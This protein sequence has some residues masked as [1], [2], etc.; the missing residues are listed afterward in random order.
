M[1]VLQDILGWAGDRDLWQQDALRRLILQAKLST[2]DLEELTR[3]CL[4]E[5]A[6]IDEDHRAPKAQPLEQKHLPQTHATSERVQLVGI[7]DVKNVNILAPEQKMGFELDGLT[8]VF[9]YNGSGKSGYARILR[10][11]CHAR[12]RSDQI[13]PD[14]FAQGQPPTPSATIDFREGDTDTTLQWEQGSPV[15]SMLQQVSFFDT[16]CATVHVNEANE[17]A[18]TPFGLDVMPKL[19]KVCHHI[20]GKIQ[21]MITEQENAKPTFLTVPQAAEGTDVRSAIDRI[22]KDS[23]IEQFQ[24]LANLTQEDIGR[25]KELQEMLATDPVLRTKE[26]RNTIQRLGLLRSK[27]L[28]VSTA[29]SDNAVS[30]L[31]ELYEYAKTKREAAQFVANDAFGEQP[32]AGVGEKIWQE[33]WKAARAYSTVHAYPEDPF[34]HTEND[35]RCVLCHQP[36]SDEARTRL[37]KFENFMQA[38]TQK[39]ADDAQIALD[40][41]LRELEAVP[42]GR[43]AIHEH[44]PDIP[45]GQENLTTALRRF[46]GMAWKRRCKIQL[47]RDAPTW[48]SP[49][50]LPT[51]PLEALDT[52]I[53]QLK[54]RA[55]EVDKSADRDERSKLVQERKNLEARQWLAKVLGDINPEISRKRTLASLEDAR[56]STTT[57]GITRQ[58]TTLTRTYVTDV[59]CE[60]MTEEI[61]VLGAGH[62]RVGLEPRGGQQGTQLYQ[63][64]LDGVAEGLR[65]RDV[66]SE[67]EFRCIALAGFLA[68][69]ST[70][71]S[72]SALVFDDPVS[73]L[74]HLWRRR[75]AQRLVKEAADRQVV[76]FTHEIGFLTDLTEFCAK[77]DIRQQCCYLQR[78]SYH[79]GVCLD[80]L[81]WPAM[82]LNDRIRCL[83]SW[84]QKAHDLDGDAYEREA[85]RLYGLLRECWERAVEEVLLNGVITRFER[86]V[87]TMRLRDVADINEEDITAVDE[88]MAKCSRFLTGHDEP[89]AVMDPVPNSDELQTDISALGEWAKTIR[90]RRN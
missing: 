36:L 71:Q 14:A 9:G 81:P 73:S 66:L 6:I 50:Q 62:L 46:H 63:L 33:L 24:E 89:S 31:K 64:A 3:I 37:N 84:L 70:E 79:A 47:C 76:V 90:R 77:Q 61:N 48:E 56:R 41:A 22:N 42:V 82:K 28:A 72:G 53:N 20:Q 23:N 17:L 65:T 40:N 83:N 15:P 1:G 13:L 10:S 8:V 35:A 19:V 58:S 60:G 86:G 55:D 69:L 29:L 27:T 51:A 4:E 5:H 85:R 25:L 67:G 30:S 44:L 43:C 68:E 49:C 39:E 16:Q 12:H 18:F 54:Q 21:E 75:V 57:T 88:G 38:T 32:L 74:D 78:D 87:Q 11:V 52:L 34:P 26:L 45:E 2:D 7:R 59:L 80:Q